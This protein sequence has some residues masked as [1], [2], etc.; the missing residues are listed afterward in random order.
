MG[1]C[2]IL[3][4]LYVFF[5]LTGT[6]RFLKG[7]NV[8]GWMDY[9]FCINF[10]CCESGS[11][12]WSNGERPRGPLP[13]E[14]VSINWPL[15]VIFFLFFW[16]AARCRSGQ[17]SAWRTARVEVFVFLYFIFMWFVWMR[18]SMFLVFFHFRLKRD[19]E[20]RHVWYAR[21]VLFWKI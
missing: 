8:S 5:C 7:V 16:P 6:V 19:S 15:G 3:R 20:H 4:L 1:A 2:F 11:A 9:L 14:A 10:I 17:V 18:L 13:L 12:W 21:G